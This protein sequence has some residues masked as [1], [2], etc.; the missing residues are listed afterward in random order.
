MLNYPQFLKFFPISAYFA[1]GKDPSY[2]SSVIKVPKNYSAQYKFVLEAR[3][4]QFAVAPSD[5]RD[6]WSDQL[7]QESV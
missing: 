5:P 7:Q 6:P 3:Y 4:N 1:F 2:L